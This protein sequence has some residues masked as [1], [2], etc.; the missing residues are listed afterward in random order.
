[1]SDAFVIR[2]PHLPGFVPSPDPGDP[3]NATWLEDTRDGSC[4]WTDNYDCHQPEDMCLGRDLDAFVYNLNAEAALV[5]SLEAQV[6]SL[7]VIAEA[8]RD[9]FDEHLTDEP[10]M[11]Y[12]LDQLGLALGF[13]AGK[14]TK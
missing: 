14:W 6:A 1:M 4:V 2:W 11:G 8:A 12:K 10:A 13:V 5:A 9:V 3:A 7:L